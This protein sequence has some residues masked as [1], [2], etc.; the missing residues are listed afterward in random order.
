MNFVPPLF[1]LY[2]VLLILLNF[3]SLFQRPW[4]SLS[5]LAPA[6]VYWPALLIQ[7]I[8]SIPRFGLMHSVTAF[9]LLFATHVLYGLG[10]WR[11][12]FTQVDRSK[13]A[14][15]EVVIERMTA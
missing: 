9:P 11:G 15:T 4:V 3:S 13:P 5:I 2:L 14:K 1:V 12:L 10:F 6:L 7:A 8:T